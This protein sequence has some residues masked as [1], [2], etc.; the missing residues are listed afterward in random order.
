MGVEPK[1][2]FSTG[3][4]QKLMNDIIKHDS[5]EKKSLSKTVMASERLQNYM[6]ELTNETNKTSEPLLEIKKT[7]EIDAK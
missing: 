3:R 2:F 7:G 6:F 4:P 5:I 1:P